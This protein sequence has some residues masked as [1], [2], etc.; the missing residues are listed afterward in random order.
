MKILGAC[1][2]LMGIG[3]AVTALSLTFLLWLGKPVGLPC[4]TASQDG[5]L[6]FEYV[7]GTKTLSF[8]SDGDSLRLAGG[9]GHNHGPF[10][11]TM[12]DGL[13]PGSPMHLERCGGGIVRLRAG[14]REVYELT[15][16]NAEDNREAGMQQ[17]GRFAIYA[18]LIAIL[19]LGLARRASDA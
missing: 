13:P 6:D 3:V 7:F 17:T 9:T 12:F 16:K 15:Q 4:H 19:G 1:F 2:Y 8:H 14:G 18:T 5:T 10:P 11:M